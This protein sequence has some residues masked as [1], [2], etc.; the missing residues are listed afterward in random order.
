MSLRTLDVLDAMVEHRRVWNARKPTA[1]THEPFIWHAPQTYERGLDG[2]EHLFPRPAMAVVPAPIWE[3]DVLNLKRVPR[4]VWVKTPG[5]PHG[6]W[7]QRWPELLAT[8]EKGDAIC[9][10][11]ESRKAEQSAMTCFYYYARK[12]G[13]TLRTMRKA[14]L[15]RLMWV[16]MKTPREVRQVPAAEE[17]IRT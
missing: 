9:V 6:E 7:F 8:K 3:P 13:L 10:T 12:V 16:E 4:P 11:F 17:E 1:E 5:S 15:Q 14:T 2:L